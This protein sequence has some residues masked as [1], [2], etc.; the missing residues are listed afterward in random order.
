M[1]ALF[2]TGTDTGVGKTVISGLLGRFL[3]NRGYR[4]ITQKWIQTGSNFPRDINLHLKL[5]KIKAEDIRDCQSYLSPYIFK[6]PSSPHL[7]SALERKRISADRIKRSF[8]CLSDKSDFLIVEG[9]G[10]ALVPF[11][12][13]R[14]VI[15]IAKELN[16]PVLI[17]A[18]NRLGA[19]NHALLT[20]EAIERRK[21]NI[22]GII[23]N[24][25]NRKT[26]DIILK[27]NP[28]II[29]KLTGRVILG[30][31]PWIKDND[32]LYKR[33]IPIAKKLIG[34]LEEKNG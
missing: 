12:G 15:D 2:V 29:K 11:N 22:I 16:L 27:D 7:A 24:N 6:F 30:I 20:I 25:Q 5:M 17:V 33:F 18:G 32:L 26:E 34:I 28:L 13:R 19:I 10:G 31:L 9:I 8:E 21:M 23:F 1:R 14:L 3:S 4:V